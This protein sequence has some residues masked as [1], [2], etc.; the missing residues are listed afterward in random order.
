MGVTLPSSRHVAASPRAGEDRCP[1]ILAFHE[2]EDGLLLRVRVPGGRLSA[3][4][5]EVVGRLAQVGNGLV[6]I[7]ARANL[8]VRGLSDGSAA[9][10][11]RLLEASGLLPSRTHERVRNILASPLAGRHPQ[12]VAPVDEVVDELDRRLCADP[13]L[14]ALPRRFAFAIDDGSG[15]VLEQ[16]TDVALVAL[17]GESLAFTLAVAGVP[18]A[19]ALAPEHAPT[20]ALD[21]ARA[22]LELRAR[23]GE[24]AWRVWELRGGGAAVID[25]LGLRAA[26]DTPLPRAATVVPGACRQRDGCWAVT[27]LAP[28]GR[29]SR[30]ALAH[31]A[32]GGQA[33]LSACRTLTIVDLPAERVAAVARGLNEIGLVTS[34]D[35]GW[36]GLSACAGLGACAKARMDVRAAAEQRAAVRGPDA[37]AEHW[38][39]CERRCGR[40][41]AAVSVVALER[42]PIVEPARRK[43]SA[44]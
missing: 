37:P 4:Q 2:A 9:A 36:H 11:A 15:A 44:A 41:P 14:A 7:T 34:P 42:G 26:P 43:G 33:R 1:G 18:T 27:A 3:G 25:G 10:A 29:L 16:R 5:L 6:E 21:A 28:L 35:S 19:T 24:P 39:A 40:P 17:P 32:S 20:A 13:L 31:L 30:R 22:F 38:S 8:Q 23:A 12:A